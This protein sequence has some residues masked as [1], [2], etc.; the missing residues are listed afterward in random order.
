MK[1]SIDDDKIVSSTIIVEE[2]DGT[3]ETKEAIEPSVDHDV[4]IIDETAEKS[5]A[6]IADECENANVDVK[7]TEDYVSEVPSDEENNASSAASI[8]NQEMQQEKKSKSGFFGFM[9]NKP[10][11]WA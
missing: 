5:S 6:V 4:T 2:N 8:E 10:Q 3:V 7:A 1:N 9:K 11:S